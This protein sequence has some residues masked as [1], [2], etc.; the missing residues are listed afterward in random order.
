MA[1]MTKSTQTIGVHLNKL[2]QGVHHIA[3]THMK[4]QSIISTQEFAMCPLAMPLPEGE[5]HSYF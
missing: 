5:H 1:Y 3:S 4:M 2:L